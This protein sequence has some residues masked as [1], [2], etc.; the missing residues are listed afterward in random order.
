MWDLDQSKRI[1]EGF[2]IEMNEI[3]TTSPSS[4]VGR[5]QGS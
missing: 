3:I 5:A 1:L 4:S 2:I